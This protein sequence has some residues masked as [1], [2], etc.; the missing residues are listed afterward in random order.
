MTNSRMKLFLAIG[1]LVCLVASLAHVGLVNPAAAD[2]GRSGRISVFLNLGEG[3]ATQVNISDDGKV[4]AAAGNRGTSLIDAASGRLIR[5]LSIDESDDVVSTF[6]A[7]T[8]TGDRVLITQNNVYQLWDAAAGKVILSLKDGVDTDSTRTEISNDGKSLA[9]FWRDKTTVRV[10]DTQTGVLRGSIKSGASAIQDFAFLKDSQYLATTSK[11]RVIRIWN[12]K[13]GTQVKSLATS[14]E[15]PIAFDVSP[16]GQHLFAVGATTAQ[17]WEIDSGRLV[18]NVKGNFD[19]PDH[20][21]TPATAFSSDGSRFYLEDR[22]GVGRVF[23]TRDGKQTA[24]LKFG[25]ETKSIVFPEDGNTILSIGKD[26]IRYFDTNTG[27]QSSAVKLGGEYLADNDEVLVARLQNGDWQLRKLPG[28]AILTTYGFQ[29]SLLLQKLENVAGPSISTSS[30]DDLTAIRSSQDRIE[31]RNIS[32]WA[33]VS[34]CSVPPGYVIQQVRF[35]DGGDIVGWLATNKDNVRQVGGCNPASGAQVG[36]RYKL[37]DEEYM[38]LSA[39]GSIITHETGEKNRNVKLKS[40]ATGKLVASF[41]PNTISVSTVRV[42]PNEKVVAAGTDDNQVLVWSTDTGKLLRN[43]EMIPGRGG[44]VVSVAISPDSKRVAA[45]TVGGILVN[46]WDIDSGNLV[47]KF[48]SANTV[49]N[50][51]T[52]GQRGE[53]AGLDVGSI[54]FAENRIAVSYGRSIIVWDQDSGREVWKAVTQRNLIREVAFS[55]KGDRIVS[56]S[57]E[58][59]IDRWDATTGELLTSMMPLADGEWILLTPEGFFDAS[60]AKAARNLNVVRGLEVYSID[61]FRDA[62]FRPDLVRAKLAGDPDGVVKAAAARLD[63]TKVVDSGS[64]P[65]VA[66]VSPAPGASLT[67]GETEFTAS[68]TEQGGGVGRIEWRVNGQPVG[69]ATRGFGRLPDNAP[70]GAARTVS[71]RIALDPGSN[72]VELVAYNARGLVASQPARVT[73]TATGSL[74]AQKPRLFVLAVG[75]NDYYDGRLKLNFAASDARSVAAAFDQAGKGLYDEVRTTTVLDADVTKANLDSVFAKLAPQVRTTDAFVFFV[76]GHGRTLDGHYYF[77]PQDFRYV[78]Q[79]SFASGAISQEQW[80]KWISM[81]QARKSVLVYDTC[82]SGSVAADDAGVASRG[83]QRVEEQGVAY[84]KLRDAT[85]RTILAASTDTQ[86]A[87][88][89]FHGHGVFSY[90]VMEALAK[91]QTNADGLIEVT[92]L[93]SYVD[94]RVPEISY[95]V[96]H[97]HQIPQNKM[98]GS[99]FPIGR[100]TGTVVDAVAAP[101]SGPD[102][103]KPPLSSIPPAADIPTK[104]THV[105]VQPADIFEQGGGRGSA[106]QQLPTGTLLS[107]VRTDQGWAFV[108]RDGKPIGYV[109][110]DHLIRVQ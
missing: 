36:L 32:T 96:F 5:R 28:G 26:E 30:K 80:Q 93:I 38:G 75:V 64:A 99:N 17:L 51:A 55:S 16:S 60:S 50:S 84:Q 3:D 79:D 83:L 31:I 10:F 12:T 49:H 65:K 70:A 91:S 72:V 109:A 74:P 62:L 37:G 68:I 42:A 19:N 11:D 52:L 88:E 100:P 1:S 58:G 97:T 110:A 92:G 87:L 101:P 25:Q 15:A 76:A 7:M 27:H 22:S 8:P 2:A 20:T 43:F 4:I 107:V 33:K 59:V 41:K 45:G 13:D 94:D 106:I 63:L 78:D 77:L 89:G 47:R 103:A 14:S 104:P 61:Q 35:S 81:I 34:E 57:D 54:A 82:E 18:L 56:T 39:A 108:A 95:Q 105:V 98:V 46:L 71:Q 90:A 102:G 21:F 40:L 9:T 44:M 23:G 6:N 69:V 86:P 73:V 29:Q 48:T 24:S 85:G 66:I 67:A 53:G